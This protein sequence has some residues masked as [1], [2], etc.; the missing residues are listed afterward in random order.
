MKQYSLIFLTAMALFTSGCSL[1][2]KEAIVIRKVT[3]DNSTCCLGLRLRNGHVY[4]SVIM[5]T[6]ECSRF[7]DGELVLIYHTDTASDGNLRVLKYL[8]EAR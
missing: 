3:Y 8:R 4:T 6:S 1:F 5:T 2:T 7:E